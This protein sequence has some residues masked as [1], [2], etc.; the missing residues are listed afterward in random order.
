MTIQLKVASKKAY[1]WRVNNNFNQKTHKG[2]PYWYVIDNQINIFAG[3]F[4]G[5]NNTQSGYACTPHQKEALA[6]IKN[7]H[8]AQENLPILTRKGPCFVSGIKEACPLNGE[9]AQ[10]FE[11]AV[12]DAFKI[13]L[14]KRHFNAMPYKAAAHTCCNL[15]M[16]HHVFTLQL[17]DITAITIKV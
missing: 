11:A 9:L 5:E 10:A 7:F 16:M 13:L 17:I 14:E 6:Y 15:G 3:G 12:T 2:L 1:V 8:W 4:N